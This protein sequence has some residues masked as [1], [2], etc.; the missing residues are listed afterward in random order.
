MT[1]GSIVF[2]REPLISYTGPLGFVQILETPILN[3]LGFATL[4]ATNASRMAK[5]IY[6]KKCVEFGIRRA[7]GPDGGFSASSYAFLGGFEGTSNMKASQIYNLPC[8]GTMSHAF[9]TSFVSLEEIDEFEINNIPIKKRSL[10]IRKQLNFETHDGELAA[11]L[12]YAKA[13]S[14]NFKTLIDTYSTLESGIL[15]TIIVSKALSEAGINEYGIRLDSGDLCELSKQC[16]AIWNKYVPQLHFTIF[17]SDDLHEDRLIEMEAQ[18]S[19]IDVYAIGTHIATCKKQPAL[20]LVCKL[21]EINKA[22]RMKFSSDPEKATLP[23]NKA[24]Y[25]VWTD[26]NE[27]ASFDLITLEE[28][29]FRLGEN[30]IYTLSKEVEQVHNI[31]KMTRLNEYLDISKFTKTLLENKSNVRTSMRD[32]PDE[33]FN[34]SKPAKHEIMM[35]E[36][37]LE[38]FERVRKANELHKQKL[39]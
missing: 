11:F 17:A 8:M 14:N 15:N 1:E 25:R 9:I 20:G 16:R 2:A 13:F 12:A 19:Q 31:V 18:G 27:K 34:L 33:I 37:F 32:L 29:N 35:S 4:V 36:K 30:K 5:A 23:C 6:P 26:K 22:P 24:I 39:E 10:E 21:T 38:S 7:Q 3:L 28:E